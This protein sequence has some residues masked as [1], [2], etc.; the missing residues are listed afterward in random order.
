[1]LLAF[2]VRT[3]ESNAIKWHPVLPKLSMVLGSAGTNNFSYMKQNPLL[4]LL[5]WDANITF[6]FIES[7]SITYMTS[8]RLHGHGIKQ[9]K[10]HVPS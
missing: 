8:A 2:E 3:H 6:L 4:Q 7:P 9:T 5:M 1:M 10:V